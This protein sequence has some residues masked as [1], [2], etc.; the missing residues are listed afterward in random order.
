MLLQGEKMK[1]VID[2]LL[3][4]I[5][6]SEPEP[7]KAKPKRKRKRARNKNGTFKGD[8]KSTKDVNEAWEEE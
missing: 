5:W 6:G 1:E 3:E 8:D 2:K 7:K 4:L